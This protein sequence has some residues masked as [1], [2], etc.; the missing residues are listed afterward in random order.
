MTPLISVCVPTYN[1]SKYLR[2]CLD[3]ILAQTFTDFELLIVDNQSSDETL[4]IVKEYAER[5]LRI[6][7]IR[8]KRNIGAVPNFNRCLELAQ[9]EWIK[10]V[11]ADDFIAPD[12]LEQ[13][14]AASKPESCIICCR[15]DF[16]FEPSVDEQT[17]A[18]YLKHLSDW[19]IDT[20][21]SDS[22]EISAS[23][24]CK[25]L[26]DHFW[27]NIV[28]EPTAIMLHRNTFYRFGTFNTHLVGIC[29]MELW[30]RI[31]INAGLIYIP[32]TLATSRVHGESITNTSKTN[33]DRDYCLS[34][35]D[36]LVLIHDFAFHPLYAPLRT[37]ASQH[38]P[39]IYFED[40]LAKRGSEARRLAQQSL[41]N[42][43][44]SNS[45]LM[46]KWENVIHFYPMLSV[47][48]NPSLFRYSRRWLR[49]SQNLIPKLKRKFS[50][51]SNRA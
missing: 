13:M 8:N 29:D 45:S 37:V 20:L 42:S 7:V 14:L 41:S 36:R 43:A 5:D 3:S 18:F 49:K 16:L 21:F 33:S 4:S 15:R 25:V 34:K 46:Q 48:S 11:F 39:P 24:F 1:A 47:L 22:T 28:G 17:K 9:G 40:L 2:E 30:A 44:N 12:C 35:L 38:Q 23:N 32:K 6:R 27:V 26:I 10:Y 50:Q 31:G 19:S 51:I